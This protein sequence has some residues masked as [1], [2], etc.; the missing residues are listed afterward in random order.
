MAP[1]L[2]RL[3]AAPSTWASPVK[4]ELPTTT[5]VVIVPPGTV[6]TTGSVMKTVL[7][8]KAPVKE[9]P[10]LAVPRRAVFTAVRLAVAAPVGP[11]APE[12]PE[13]ARPLETAV[14]LAGPVL[15]VLVADDC[16]RTSPEFPDLA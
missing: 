6:Q 3:V 11:M 5:V 7:P 12:S 13:R 9:P 10:T 16:A 4:P 2:A 15:P 14:E 1:E 8:E